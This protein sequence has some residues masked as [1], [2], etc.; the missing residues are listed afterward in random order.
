MIF[1]LIKYFSIKI[2][3]CDHYLEVAFSHTAHDGVVTGSVCDS[4]GS[5]KVKLFEEKVNGLD[6]TDST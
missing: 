4:M 6:Y 5:K 3:L 1:P 2:P